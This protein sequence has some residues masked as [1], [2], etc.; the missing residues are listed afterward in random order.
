MEIIKKKSI[1]FIEP[2]DEAGCTVGSIKW[3]INE[4]NS[5]TVS[6]LVDE[7]NDPVVFYPFKQLRVYCF[8]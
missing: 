4:Q 6:W 3:K 2:Q 1:S 7:I 5:L 8:L